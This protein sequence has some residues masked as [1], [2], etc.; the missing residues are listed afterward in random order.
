MKTRTYKIT[1]GTGIRTIEAES[2]MD[3]L[4]KVTNRKAEDFC[5]VGVNEYKYFKAQE[6]HQTVYTVTTNAIN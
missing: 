4:E 2:A 3:A 6:E 1:N 5:K